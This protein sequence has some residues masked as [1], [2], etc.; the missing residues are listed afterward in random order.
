MLLTLYGSVSPFCFV[1]LTIHNIICVCVLLDRVRVTLVLS[2]TH[3]GPLSLV[4]VPE[5]VP[6]QSPF[7]GIELVGNGTEGG[8]NIYETKVTE[9]VCV[10]LVGMS[11]KVYR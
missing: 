2:L 4:P 10:G 5:K 11:W 8:G 6:R 7:R 9:D 3:R 1:I